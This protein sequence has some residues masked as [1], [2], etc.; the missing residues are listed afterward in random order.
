MDPFRL[1]LGGPQWPNCFFYIVSG[2]IGQK[3]IRFN[4]LGIY[5]LILLILSYRGEMGL[6]FCERF[7]CALITSLTAPYD[8]ARGTPENFRQRKAVDTATI[9]LILGGSHS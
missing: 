1:I 7:N 8:D 9:R 4:K 6:E 2:I 3:R 5:V